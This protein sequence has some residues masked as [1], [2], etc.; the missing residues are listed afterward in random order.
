MKKNTRDYTSDRDLLTQNV[1]FEI[2]KKNYSSIF[3]FAMNGNVNKIS[4]KSLKDIF[5]I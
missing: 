5:E 1:R 3:D 4:T 2:S